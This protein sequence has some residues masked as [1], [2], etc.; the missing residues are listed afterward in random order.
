VLLA[1]V[2]LPISA[3]QLGF[4]AVGFE[5]FYCFLVV[6]QGCCVVFF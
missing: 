1:V 5:V 6:V 3:C 4:I 2:D